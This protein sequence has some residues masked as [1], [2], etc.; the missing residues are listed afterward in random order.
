M[1]YINTLHKCIS[2]KAVYIF[3][4]SFN[5]TN[6]SLILLINV[7]RENKNADADY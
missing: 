5:L 2:L 1:K 3:Y 6:S 7:G 4:S